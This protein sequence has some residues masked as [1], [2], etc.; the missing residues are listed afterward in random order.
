[1]YIEKFADAYK[2]WDRNLILSIRDTVRPGPRGDIS[3][4]VFRLGA[5][6]AGAGFRS[7]DSCTIEG[8]DGYN[9]QLSMPMANTALREIKTMIIQA[10]KRQ[11]LQVQENPFAGMK[12]AKDCS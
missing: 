1:M 7:Y 8:G 9:P 3:P 4:R 12:P 5:W 11:P 2:Y 10:K 6:V